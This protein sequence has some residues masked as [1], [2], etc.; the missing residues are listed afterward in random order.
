MVIERLQNFA[1]RA[2]TA[3]LFVATVSGLAFVSYGVGD[4]YSRH[5]AR[6]RLKAEQEAAR[7]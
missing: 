2:F 5:L 3:T 7:Q 4:L 6:K 1:H